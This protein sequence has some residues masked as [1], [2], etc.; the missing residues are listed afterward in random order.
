MVLPSLG[1]VAAKDLKG[2]SLG[3]ALHF[4][5]ETSPSS[6][7][8]TESVRMCEESPSTVQVPSMLA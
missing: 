2:D 6:G 7:E 4:A 8:L 3:F 1:C 5:C